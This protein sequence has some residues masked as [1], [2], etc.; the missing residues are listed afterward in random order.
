MA[1][2]IDRLRDELLEPPR[3][4]S[5]TH[6]VIAIEDLEQHAPQLVRTAKEQ[7]KRRYTRVEH[8][9]DDRAG[10]PCA[11][12]TTPDEPCILHAHLVGHRRHVRPG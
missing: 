6:S 4:P 7:R 1:S 11:C 5:V 2:L 8:Y 3:H 12:G 10:R 9:E